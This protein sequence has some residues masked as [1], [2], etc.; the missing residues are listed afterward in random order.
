MS[1]RN[2][3][4]ALDALL[5][6]TAEKLLELIRN[7]RMIGTHIKITVDEEDLFRDT[8]VFYKNP[9]FDASRPIVITMA[10]QPGLDTGGIRRD[11]FTRV[12]D[13]FVEDALSIFMGEIHHFRPHHSPQVLPLLKILGSI[14][15]HSLVQGGPYL[16]PYVYWYLA[17]GSEETSLIF[18]TLEDLTPDVANV[19]QEVS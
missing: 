19:V 8:L 7:N 16:A 11:F 18:V 6:L 10:N 2:G 17:T 13:L 5:D 1:D 9:D 15:V 14:I 3:N 12:L 4:L